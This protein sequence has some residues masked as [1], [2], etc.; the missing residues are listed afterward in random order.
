VEKLNRDVLSVV[1]LAQMDDQYL[2]PLLLLDTHKQVMSLS[3]LLA[4]EVCYV[5]K[6]FCINSDKSTMGLYLIC[7]YHCRQSNVC[8]VLLLKLHVRVLCFY[9]QVT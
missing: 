7:S 2:R 8:S 3:V 6:Y 4:L 5:L 1:M 9:L